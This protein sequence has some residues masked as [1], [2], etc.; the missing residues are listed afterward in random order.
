MQK[1]GRWSVLF[2]IIPWLFI[3]F[4]YV[5]RLIGLGFTMYQVQGKLKLI[6]PVVALVLGILAMIFDNI[7]T[8]AIVGLVIS[9]IS[10]VMWNI[11]VLGIFMCYGLYHHIWFADVMIYL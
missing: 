2:A 10:I 6:C 9:I 1:I 5:A 7:K 3:L 11:I 4:H 8:S